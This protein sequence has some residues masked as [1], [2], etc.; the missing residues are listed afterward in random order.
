[1]RRSDETIS[2]K[3]LLFSVFLAVLPAAFA[4]DHARDFPKPD[5]MPKPLK[6]EQP[7]YPLGLRYA[8]V[9]GRVTLDAILD[10]QGNVAEVHV[11]R[12]NNP[13]FERPAID[14]V[15]KWKFTP[16]LKDGHPVPIQ[17]RQEIYFDMS[18]ITTQ[19]LWSITP[20]KDPSKL[21]PEYRWDIAPEPVSTFMP[22]YPFEA[23]R[24]RKKGKATV[25]YV[26]GTDGRVIAARVMEATAPEFGAA[27]LAMIDGWRF[28]PA[29]RSADG[30][31]A[32]AIIAVVREFEPDGRGDVPVSESA[33][34]LVSRLRKNKLESVRADELDAPPKP[35]SQR[36]PIYP[37][38]LREAGQDGEAVIEFFI[39]ERGDAQ[40]PRIVSA[41]APEFGYAA[42]QAVATWRYAPP[43]K[44]GKAVVTRVRQPLQF[45]LVELPERET[46][47]PVP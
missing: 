18:G 25:R 8:G 23:L 12:S 2:M 37:S 32:R 21:P 42:A 3:T 1:M 31:A 10:L 46:G 24:E 41:T 4:A 15:M 33:Q 26:I 20:P 43:K 7:F 19:S 38:P 22:A 28:K 11:A 40:L 27:T 35:V 44:G 9:I 17:V 45:H 13:F 39:D 16:A 6:Q 34:W 36:P 29:R 30:T 5:T 47:E 14:A